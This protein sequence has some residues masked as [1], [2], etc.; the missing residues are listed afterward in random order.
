MEGSESSGKDSERT[1]K[2]GTGE[3]RRS[4]LPRP[5]RP[6]RSQILRGRLYRHLAAA[7]PPPHRGHITVRDICN[8]TRKCISLRLNGSENAR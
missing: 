3:D 7:E 6:E 2:K 1:V 4:G 5:A 8:T